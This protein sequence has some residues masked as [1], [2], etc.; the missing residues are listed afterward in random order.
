[1]AQTQKLSVL[2]GLQIKPVSMLSRSST[3]RITGIQK[4]RDKR[5]SALHGKKDD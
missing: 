4:A 1:M 3:F 2:G 5:A